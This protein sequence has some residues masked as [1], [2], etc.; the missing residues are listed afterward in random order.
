MAV[1]VLFFAGARE[2]VGTGQVD[3][4]T[5]P[6]EPLSALLDRLCA[7]YPALGRLRGSSFVAVN[8]EYAR[9]ETILNDGD[10]VAWIPPVSGG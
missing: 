6:G 4:D 1:R 5:I 10:E 3:L 2:Q 9:P 7:L 8:Q